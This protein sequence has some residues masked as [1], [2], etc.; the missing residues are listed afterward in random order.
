MIKTKV[1]KMEVGGDELIALGGFLVI[2]SLL[3]T[4]V[5]PVLDLLQFGFSFLLGWLLLYLGYNWKFGK[6]PSL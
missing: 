2:I 3:S 1:V 4:L 5:L 6:S